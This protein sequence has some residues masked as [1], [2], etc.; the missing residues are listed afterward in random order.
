MS[1]E[2]VNV[3]VS[4]IKVYTGFCKIIVA[5]GIDSQLTFHLQP[6]FRRCKPNQKLVQSSE[7]SR[8]SNAVC[9]NHFEKPCM[10]VGSVSHNL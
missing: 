5:N 7:L 8:E 6:Y 3:R 9:D 2:Y 10:C 4:I 1:E